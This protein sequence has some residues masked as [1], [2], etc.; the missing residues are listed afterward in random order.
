MH[1]W[2]IHRVEETDST[3]TQLKRMATVGAPEGTVLIA[4]R[5]TDGHGR[6][7]RTFHSPGGGL[8]MSVLLRRPMAEGVSPLWTVAAAV[9]AAEAC[10]QLC[11]EAVGIKWVND[12]YL[13]ERKVCGILAE[14]MTDLAT[15]TMCTVVGFGVN[16][17]PPPHGF[18]AEIAH[19]AGALCTVAPPDAR[20]R[21]AETLLSHFAAYAADL[22]ART[23]LDGYRARSVLC[24][25]TV[26]F[27]ENGVPHI[28]A[29][30]GVDDNGGLVVE[31]GGVIRVL[32]AGEVTTHPTNEKR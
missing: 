2:R 32:A 9:A 22:E 26:T 17:T 7:G 6:M 24:G 4:D 21:L 29:V 27:Y 16:I 5:Q 13:N 23:F 30:Q 11:G 19:T 20:D 1:E 25:R 15:E 8:Y 28:V 31:E 12:L 3:N 14:S 18:A 10:E